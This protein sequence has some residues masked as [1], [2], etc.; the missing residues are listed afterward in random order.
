MHKWF[1][2]APCISHSQPSDLFYTCNN[3]MPLSHTITIW[4]QPSDSFLSHSSHHHHHPYLSLRPPPTITTGI[5][6]SRQPPSTIPPPSRIPGIASSPQPP[7]TILPPSRIPQP[8]HAFLFSNADVILTLARSFQR[9]L[10]GQVAG[11]S[12]ATFV[13]HFEEVIMYMI[14]VVFRFWFNMLIVI[15]FLIVIVNG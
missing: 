6:R 15:Q 9:D 11:I 14:F 2:Y 8:H 4:S 1:P 5:E 3:L 12:P 10:S 7:C 13:L